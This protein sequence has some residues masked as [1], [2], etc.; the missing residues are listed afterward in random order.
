MAM[1]R[2]KDMAIGKRKPRQDELFIPTAKLAAGP[3]HPSYAKFNQV[4][5][6]AGFDE[7]VERLCAPYYKDSGRPGSPPGTYF[8][9][10]FIGYFEGI[11]S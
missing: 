11:D 4:L 8:R 6:N 2:L 10:L 1:D 3:G 9:M 5:A 7:F